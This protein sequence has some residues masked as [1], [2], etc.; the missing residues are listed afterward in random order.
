LK[1]FRSPLTLTFQK[2]TNG[3][4]H[5]VDRV[6]FLPE[7]TTHILRSHDQFA[8]FRQALTKTVD[9]AVIVNDTSTH[10][11]QTIFAPTEAA[12]AKLGRKANQFFFGPG[13]EDYLRA[14]LAYHI[15]ANQTLFS[16]VYFQE[17]GRGQ[18]PVNTDSEVN[19][20]LFFFGSAVPN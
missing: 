6:L 9:L 14:L 3:Y 10:V 18:L 13:G 16:D 2:A 11:G 20:T 5:L 19:T 17:D 1:S 7:S 4:I 15:V 12:F 8:T